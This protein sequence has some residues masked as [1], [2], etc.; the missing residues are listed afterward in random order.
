MLILTDFPHSFKVLC[1][2]TLYEYTMIILSVPSWI[3][4]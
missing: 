1:G 2:F 4:F 3:A